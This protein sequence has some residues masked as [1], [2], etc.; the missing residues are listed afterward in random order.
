MT[1]NTQA[2]TD[3]KQALIN[4]LGLYVTNVSWGEVVS[5]NGAQSATQSTDGGQ[6]K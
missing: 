2:V 3:S 4:P 6:D 1:V 5:A